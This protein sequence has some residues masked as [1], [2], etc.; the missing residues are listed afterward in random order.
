VGGVH[1]RCGVWLGLAQM[2]AR[3]GQR[4]IHLALCVPVRR[5]RAPLR[6]TWPDRKSAGIEEAHEVGG[7]LCGLARPPALSSQRGRGERAVVVPALL[8][9]IGCS[10]GAPCRPGRRRALHRLRA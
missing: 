7:A 1:L 6:Y 4:S 9:R 8:H 5:L 10:P 2:P 3:P